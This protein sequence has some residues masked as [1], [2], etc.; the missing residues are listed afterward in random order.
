MKKILALGLVLMLVLSLLTACGGNSGGSS[1]ANSAPTASNSGGNDSK[2]ASTAAQESETVEY[3]QVIYDD[4]G[5]K[6]TL[7]GYKHE[8]GS[9]YISEGH[10]WY[11]TI[12]NHTDREINTRLL[13]SSVNGCMYE[14]EQGVIRTEAGETKET[15]DK[16]WLRASDLNARGITTIENFEFILWFDEQNGNQWIKYAASEP[17]TLPAP[18][19]L[20]PGFKQTFDVDGIVA[21]DR[22]G[23]KVTVIRADHDIGMVGD[24]HGIWM[25]IENNSGIDV[26]FEA[27][28]DIVNDN[29]K[30]FDGKL[31]CNILNGK[32]AFGYLEYYKPRFEENGESKIETA[33]LQFYVENFESDGHGNHDWLIGGAGDDAYITV[34]FD[35]EGKVR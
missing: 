1:T 33:E 18:V 14:L 16:V 26:N 25:F 29:P 23:I 19:P 4:N 8:A 27:A 30:Y 7:T 9:E 35:A 34:S 31:F 24:R 20:D 15:K 6:V 17:I 32:V 28:S 5:M 21:V 22:E 12:E 10:Y 2:P 13:R 3:D 11:F